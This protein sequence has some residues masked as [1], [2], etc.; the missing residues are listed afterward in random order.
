MANAVDTIIDSLTSALRPG[1]SILA[2]SEVFARTM[3]DLALLVPF[4]DATLVRCEENP[5]WV[6]TIGAYSNGAGFLP[7]KTLRKATDIGLTIVNAFPD[8][9][10][11]VPK[12]GGSASA[13]ELATAGI[14]VVWVI[15]LWSAGVSHGLFSVNR[16]IAVSFNAAEVEV[17]RRIG[18]AFAAPLGEEW[19]ATVPAQEASRREL[20]AAVC[21]WP[22]G[23]GTLA[24]LFEGSR[25]TLHRA[26][27]TDALGL[28][29]N[30]AQ[31]DLP[32]S[33]NGGWANVL[34]QNTYLNGWLPP[35]DATTDATTDVHERREA[36]HAESDS[37]GWLV[38][39][40]LRQGSDVLGYLVLRRRSLVPLGEADHTFLEVLAMVLSQSICSQ[41]REAQLRTAQDRYRELFEDAPAMYVITR[42]EAGGPVIS[43]CNDLFVRA[44]ES[45]RRHV[46][47]RRLS[48]FDAAIQRPGGEHRLTV[49]GEERQ[50]IGREG[51]VTDTLLR[52]TP[53][54]STE[55]QV[56]GT[57]AMYIDIAERKALQQQL[58][59]Q[60]F[61]DSLT[62]LP[63]RALFLDRLG[64]T[65]E[66][67]AVRQSLTAVALLDLD[68]FKVVN[69]S[70]GHA[71]G[72]ELLVAVTMRLR[73]Y[74]MPGDTLA[75]LGGDEFTVLLEDVGES[76]IA[77]ERLEALLQV[78][79]V[80]FK[81]GAR[82][83]FV[84]GSIGLVVTEG[85]E[86]G[87]NE[88]LRRSDVAMY[89]AKR[90]GKGIV[91]LFDETFQSRASLR[92]DQESEL[93]QAIE[94]G[95]IEVHYQPVIDLAD[96]SV[97]EM[98]ALARWRHPE[99][100]LLPPSEFIT[101]AEESG[102]IAALGREVLK[103]A[104]SAARKWL[105]APGVSPAFRVAVNMSVK[106]LERPRIV[107][108]V[109]QVVKE[110]GLA[111]ANLK[112]E[113]TESTMMGDGEAA[114]AKLR[115]LAEAGVSIAI[116]DFGTGY[117]SLSYL[118]RLPVDTVKIDRAFITGLGTDRSD[119]AIVQAVVA[120]AACM[121][122][123]VT[124]EGVETATQREA[125]RRM[126]CDRAQGYYF[127][128]PMPEAEAAKLLANLSGFIAAA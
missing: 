71:A 72:D 97:V 26:L 85:A 32:G 44:V 46:I 68:D 114:V 125:V 63:N 51:R 70:L 67:Q 88:L 35:T 47:G 61:H 127:S 54:L 10:E 19:S 28:F 64:H 89:E 126:G 109:L 119:T 6:R 73:S 36:Q 86:V 25:L 65:I 8:G 13:A 57:R 80:P 11:F 101:L 59:H 102:Q 17:L 83:V 43:D 75:R 31:P 56:V 100:G 42:H 81:L 116:D 16:K 52:A 121:D 20:I 118:K 120:F 50:L 84:N 66:R 110:S 1:L 4:D 117:S 99:R 122:L 30:I 58:T 91:Q 23:G 12:T 22:D 92:L 76:A 128:R 90:L 45:E 112:I 104:C 82:Q 124:V 103:T 49:S 111:P 34:A 15:P 96:G 113:V 74:L 53:E 2:L 79:D 60:A 37:L 39:A 7:A 123:T 48:D 93:R 108:E 41:R 78:F 87:A 62:D 21:R 55:G 94:N 77:V 24:E 38:S 33:F 69:D 98:E 9:L 27:P 29:L 18:A 115:L 40:R 105:A 95:E 106:Q 3:A 14:A 5:A 107:D